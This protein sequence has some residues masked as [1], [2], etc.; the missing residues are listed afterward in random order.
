MARAR[1][2]FTFYGIPLRIHPGWLLTAALV[3][4]V[5]ANLA[6]PAEQPPQSP[7]PYLGGLV[8]AVG[9]F[10]SVLL[11]ELAHAAVARRC[12]LAVRRVT[13]HIFGGTAEIDAE[14]LRP[15]SEALVAAAGPG[16]NILLAAVFGLAWLALRGMG[17][18]V[19]LGCQLLAIAN[20]AITILTL[21]PGYPLDGGRVVR[22]GL[23]YLND[24]LVA[25]T[26]WASVYG[27]VL[28]W[29]LIFGAVFLLLQDRL[30][31]ASTLAL[32]GWFLRI[33]AR[34]GY[35]EILWQDLSRR[36]PSIHT[37]F[38][39]PPRI[40]ADR[41]L[42]ESADD[43]L[44]GMGTRGEGGPSLVI[45]D[46]GKPVGVL[47]IDELRAVRRKH[48]PTTTAQSAMAPITQLLVVSPDETC[49]RTMVQLAQARYAYGLI[50]GVG[51]RR[52]ED[53]PA[54][55]II[56]PQR[57]ARHLAEGVR[58]RPSRADPVTAVG[59]PGPLDTGGQRGS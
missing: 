21:L 23:W 51:G 13:V 58:A 15:Q 45:D 30:L 38:L 41:S 35:Q 20:A 46:T 18:A 54:V 24:D 49:T 33:E 28:G 11:H 9:L 25:A 44:V 14:D 16:A 39:E 55:G 40:P 19:A 48:W 1:P 5:V 43:V 37:A 31:W 52:E 4:V 7:L 59:P 36:T 42:D 3:T 56:T 53:G 27:Q 6:D 8:I 29:T 22:A 12:G 32:G 17:G 50:L 26:R 10:C 47:G 57:I 34:R 2:E